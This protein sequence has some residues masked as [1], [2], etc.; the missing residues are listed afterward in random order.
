MLGH[1]ETDGD[2]EGE[3]D[4]EPDRLADTEPESVPVGEGVA[5]AHADGVVVK[6]CV[7]VSVAVGDVLADRETDGE[8]V[9]LRAPDAE[10][11]PVRETVL[12]SL[13]VDVGLAQYVPESV[14]E[15][16]AVDDTEN[17][18]LDVGLTDGVTD[19]LFETETDAVV[20]GEPVVEKVTV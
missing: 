2:G 4:A 18:R 7:T 20:D 17:V 8:P 12:D 3:G 19:P 14:P 5:D 16:V 15:T 6:D 1:M 9:E 11:A 13:I 10:I